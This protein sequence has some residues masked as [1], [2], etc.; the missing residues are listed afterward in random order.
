L[1]RGVHPLASP[2]AFFKADSSCVNSTGQ[3][4]Y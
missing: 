4:T 2:A 1:L 3:I